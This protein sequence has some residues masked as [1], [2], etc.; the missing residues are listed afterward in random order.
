VLDRWGSLWIAD[1]R[2]GELSILS[3]DGKTHSLPSPSLNALAPMPLGGLVAASDAKGALLFLDPAGHTRLSIPYG[4]DLPIP[5][6][7][8]MALATDPVG[9]V[10][11][12]VDG[13]FEGVVLW[14]PDGSLLRFATFKGLGLSG[15]FRG[16]ALDRQGGILLADRS[17]DLIVRLD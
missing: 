13:D 16:L 7:T 14:G 6:R 9:H 12:L 3:A 1:A 4:K 2:N 11:A 17:N 5:F 15:R 8:I 10:A